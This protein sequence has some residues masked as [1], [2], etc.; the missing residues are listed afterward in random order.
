MSECISVCV[1]ERRVYVA[2]HDNHTGWHIIPGKIQEISYIC[3]CVIIAISPY[4]YTC[5]Y[6]YI[7]I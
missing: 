6:I 5:M 1:K 7:Y 2:S 3:T 4:T